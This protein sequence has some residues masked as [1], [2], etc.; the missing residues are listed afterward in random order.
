[1]TAWIESQLPEK[2]PLREKVV[3][4]YPPFVKR[5]LHDNGSWLRASQQD[6]ADLMTEPITRIE[7]QGTVIGATLH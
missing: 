1:M 6:N 3:P 2:S 4:D 5:M 7:E